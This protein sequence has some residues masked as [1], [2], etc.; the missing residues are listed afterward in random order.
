[1]YRDQYEEKVWSWTEE[2]GVV[3]VKG[4]FW[5]LGMWSVLREQCLKSRIKSVCPY[6]KAKQ[7]KQ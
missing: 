5:H 7:S 1:M 3:S 6:L 4:T 2:L